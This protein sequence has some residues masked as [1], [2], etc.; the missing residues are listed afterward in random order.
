[1]RCLVCGG[2]KGCRWCGMEGVLEF[3]SGVCP[4]GLMTEDAAAALMAA[5]LAR[6]GKWPEGGGWLDETESAID[7]IQWIWHLEV[8]PRGKYGM[9]GD[10]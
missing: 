4:R 6:K 3:P 2:E 7:A 8:W 10:G 9:T 1:M 5:D